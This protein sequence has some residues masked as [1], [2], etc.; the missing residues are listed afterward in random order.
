MPSVNLHIPTPL[1]VLN[2]ILLKDKTFLSS[3][4][5]LETHANHIKTTLTF[6]MQ[7]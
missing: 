5:T 6:E 3:E 2:I 1:V 4:I 7:Q